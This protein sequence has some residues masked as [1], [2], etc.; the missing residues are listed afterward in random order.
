MSVVN[1]LWEFQQ[2]EIARIIKANNHSTLVAHSVG[3]GKTVT[4]SILASEMLRTKTVNKVI[5]CA[6]FTMITDAF[7][8]LWETK[9]HWNTFGYYSKTYGI[10]R[11]VKA[12]NG[13]DIIGFLTDAR[14]HIIV[15]TSKLLST[16][17]VKKSIL[18]LNKNCKIL[19]VFD[20]AHHAYN[21]KDE[22]G[23]S[24]NGTILGEIR[25]HLFNNK[26]YTIRATATPFYNAHGASHL[27]PHYEESCISM[28]SYSQQFKAGRAPAIEF[29]YVH[30][31][32]FTFQ[33]AKSTDSLGVIETP[34]T[35]M[36]YKESDIPLLAKSI[37]EQISKYK[38]PKT[39]INLPAIG[40]KKLAPLLAKELEKF[41]FPASVANKRNKRKHPHVLNATGIQFDYDPDE[42]NYDSDE[43]DKQMSM[44]E[45]DNH[46]NGRLYDIIIGCRRF[47]E[48][49]NCPSIAL[50]ISCGIS[51]YVK[52]VIQ[53]VGRG[54]R[55]KYDI[56]GYADWFHKDHMDITRVVYLIPNYF[57]VENLKNSAST[58]I[59]H[60]LI[61]TEEYVLYCNHSSVNLLDGMREI[62]NDNLDK[63]E[64]TTENKQKINVINNMINEL[65]KADSEATLN[66]CNIL[67]N[68]HTKFDT[69][70]EL[71]K[72][73]QELNSDGK[74]SDSI[75]ILNKLSD[76]DKEKFLKRFNA[77]VK[78][79]IAKNNPKLKLI[80]EKNGSNII[81]EIALEFSDNSVSYNIEGNVKTAYTI[82]TGKTVDELVNTLR[83]KDKNLIPVYS[84]SDILNFIPNVYSP[85]K[86]SINGREP[87]RKSQDPVEREIA[88]KMHAIITELNPN[89]PMV[90]AYL[91]N[92]GIDYEAA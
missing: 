22:E 77:K 69:P 71:S 43:N 15:C 58:M 31:N 63:V 51:Q 10:K 26:I 39:L 59:V 30:N 48:G 27:I 52:T 92:M 40:V 25:E 23:Y 14:N 36:K 7:I 41:N 5:L 37:W 17:D 65:C 33:N 19:F 82:A 84:T 55:N 56:D 72:V 29:S 64:C 76:S 21:E 66:S 90:K 79:L 87:S 83:E 61:A 70:T 28:Q 24:I 6:P 88:D 62:L 13:A 3:S 60:T 12:K 57:E 46:A 8:D 73:M 50:I 86:Q 53:R 67:F 11:I 75:A 49:A 1:T 18:K 89:L 91:N 32:T 81:K 47:D 78:Y 85:F 34:N 35:R 54:L 20:E 74:L 80:C 45:A 42:T 44:L 4:L 16:P 38:Y 68:M 9:P 2:H